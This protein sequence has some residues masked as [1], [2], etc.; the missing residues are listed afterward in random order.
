MYFDVKSSD[1]ERHVDFQSPLGDAVVLKVPVLNILYVDMGIY[2]P[3]RRKVCAIYR[4][5]SS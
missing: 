3:Y 2:L 1:S 4:K 5:Y